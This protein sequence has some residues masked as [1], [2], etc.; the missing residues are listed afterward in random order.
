MIASFYLDQN[1]VGGLYCEA[2]FS[3]CL[4]IPKGEDKLEKAN[5][6]RKHSGLGSKITPSCK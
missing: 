1:S 6:L 4:F 5:I 3:N 2:N